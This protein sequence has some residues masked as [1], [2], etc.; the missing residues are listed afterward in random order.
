MNK[1]IEKCRNEDI[2]NLL[3]SISSRQKNLEDLSQY[4]TELESQ[5]SLIFAASPDIILF[6]E[7][8]GTI[9]KT[10][11]AISKILGY[12]KLEIQNKKIWDFIHPEDIA[13]TK[14]FLEE[15][16]RTELLI[17][18]HPLTVEYFLNRWIKK[19]GEFA[20]LAWRFSFYNEIDNNIIGIATDITD[21]IIQTPSS[22]PMLNQMISMCNDGIVITDALSPDNVIVYT[23][24]SF[25]K[26]C[27]YSSQELLNK[28]CRILQSTPDKSQQPKQTLK[29]A[30]AEKKGCD[31]LLKNLKKD[32]TIFY[33]HLVIS[34]ITNSD[35]IVVNYLGISRDVT[36][37]I[38][39]GF[40]KWSATAERGFSV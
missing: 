18:D 11:H 30:I 31:I 38:E 2:T 21:Y 10:S 4:L 26:N 33:N 36:E 3:L 9:I 40:L 19:N 24:E 8:D 16:L 27:G 20:K 34:T 15:T 1:Y 37:K 35:G 17:V 22:I 5:L 32:G 29:N 13:K 14:K 12:T 39:T 25:Q 28:N 6:I 7:R 23:N